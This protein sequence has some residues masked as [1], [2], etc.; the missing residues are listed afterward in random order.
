MSDWSA[1]RSNGA[2][3]Q[4]RGAFQWPNTSYCNYIMFPQGRTKLWPRNVS[5][6]PFRWKMCHICSQVKVQS[7]AFSI[8]KE[9]VIFLLFKKAATGVGVNMWR[10]VK[11]RVWREQW[12][13]TY[14]SCPVIPVSV[15]IATQLIYSIKHLVPSVSCPKQQIANR[16]QVEF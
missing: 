15:I 16:K 1:C 2:W 4:S 5:V 13:T 9:S 6:A 12:R 8:W 3:P 7:A 14:A 10:V 11:H